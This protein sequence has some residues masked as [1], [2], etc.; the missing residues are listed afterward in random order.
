MSEIL[1]CGM[2]VHKDTVVV[3]VFEAAATEPTRVVKLVR[4]PRV[5]RRFFDRLA[6]QGD[7]RACYEASGAGYVLARQMAHWGRSSRRR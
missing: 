5:L 2:D 3:A 1:Y 6:K 7:L 4:E